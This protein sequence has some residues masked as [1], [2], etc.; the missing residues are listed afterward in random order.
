MTIRQT[1]VSAEFR[2][3]IASIFRMAIF[4]AV[5]LGALAG[6]LLASAGGIR[7]PLVLA[8]TAQLALTALTANPIRNRMPVPAEA[9]E[10]ID[11]ALDE[12]LID[13]VMDLTPVP[14]GVS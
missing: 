10:V 9:D 2:G 14:A 8:G 6:G 3:R 12:A 4:G 5:P 7:L 11:L 13:A 1:A